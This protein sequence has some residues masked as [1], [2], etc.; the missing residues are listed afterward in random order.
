MEHMQSEGLTYRSPPSV[1]GFS[2]ILI[3]IQIIINT[4]EPIIPM[5]LGLFATLT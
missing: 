4:I 5:Q 2:R 1:I 3:M